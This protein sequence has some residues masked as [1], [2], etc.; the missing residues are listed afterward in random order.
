MITLLDRLDVEQAY[1]CGISL[2]GLTGLWLSRFHPHRFRQLVVA[3]TAACIGTPEG[4]RQ[5]AQQVLN[6]GLIPIAKASPS[7]WFTDTF[8]QQAQPQVA[9]LVTQLAQ[10]NTVGY[11]ACCEALALADLRKETPNMLVPMLVIAGE[12]DPV[13]TVQDARWLVDNIPHAELAI[14]PTS[15]ISHV[16]CPVLFNQ[17]TTHFFRG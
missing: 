1:F 4:W 9:S 10:G 7:R 16:E 5:R 13:T 6:E 11:A 17:C 12:Q 14:L 8:R 3:N 15:H 2:G